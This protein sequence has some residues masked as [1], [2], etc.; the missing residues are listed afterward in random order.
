MIQGIAASNGIAIAKAYQLVTP[1]LTYEKK[2]I[3][4]PNKEVER[5]KD[6]L[7]TAKQELEKIREHTRNEMGD[8]HAEIFSAHLLVLDDP[9]L[10]NPIKD[11]ITNENIMAEAALEETTNMFI[12]MFKN[13]DNEYMRERAAD[14]QDVSKRV[15]A[16][17]LG[18]TVPSPALIDEEVIVIANDLTPSD[19]AQLNRE[20]VQGFATNIGGRTSHSAIMA[21]SLEIPAV[22]GT[23]KITGN[24]KQGDMLIV[25]GIE[26]NV[27]VN[28][29]D[30]ELTAYRA[31]QERFEKQKEVW[32]KLKDEPTITADKEQ[33]E[34]AANIG[35][36]DDVA[37]VLANGGEGIGLYRTEFL[38]MGKNQLPTED[39]QYDAYQSV[40]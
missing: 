5:L 22:V 33:V 17:L 13:M 1:E 31:K 12:D 25:D 24:V 10:V 29:S 28:P 15:L 7:G 2:S 26:G 30:E 6:A 34:L 19:T 38:Y 23:K 35:T 4:N 11:K 32:A 40:L 8:E 16:H 27:I 20:F 21:R 37:S 18:V 9:E 3:D 39:E 14:I 36:P